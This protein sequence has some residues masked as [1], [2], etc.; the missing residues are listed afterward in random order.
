MT[1]VRIGLLLVASATVGCASQPTVQQEAEVGR[2]VEQ[3]V[4]REAHLLRDEPLTSYVDALGERL[5]AKLEP[6]AVQPSF[7]VAESDDFN[8]SAHLGGL[9]LVNTGLILQVTNVS[10][11]AGVI[12]H[13]IGHVRLRHVA[14]NYAKAK[15]AGL[16]H[17]VLSTAGQAA[18]G[19][20]G[21]LAASALSGLSLST[22][23]NSFTREHEAEADRF[24]VTALARAGLDPNGVIS[25]FETLERTHGGGGAVP[26]FL[27]S[28]PTE[29]AR[30]A[31]ARAAVAELG[32]LAG[33]Q[34]DDNGRLEI[35]Q[36]RVRLL[37][38][39]KVPGL[40][41]PKPAGDP[42]AS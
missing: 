25:L 18:Y 8:A 20:P 14:Q 15:N 33:L 13:E 17:Q 28:H 4:L 6:H 42:R 36:H 1:R 29:A 22:Y 32:P 41:P 2:R 10:E 40:A 12:A 5:V 37:T 11:L 23:L 35:I 9:I 39:K 34:K 30:V 21:G 7:R 38:G 31:A 27:R 24:A 16:L 19:L 26:G 3:Q